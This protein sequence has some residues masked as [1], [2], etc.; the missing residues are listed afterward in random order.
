[1]SGDNIETTTTSSPPPKKEGIWLFRCTVLILFVDLLVSILI[2][3]PILPWVRHHEHEHDDNDN[4][5]N[6]NHYTF[7]G[8]LLDL[9]ILSGCR[10][11]SASIAFT[12]SFCRGN[13]SKE[14][15][16]DIYH[17]NKTKKTRDELEEEALQ[18]SFTTW[19][20]TYVNRSAVPFEIFCFLTALT[21]VLK[22]LDR[23]NIEM[24]LLKDTQ[25]IHP[26]FWLAFLFAAI[27]SVLEMMYVDT[28]CINLGKWGSQYY[29]DDENN[30][31]P[32]MLRH[33]S[34]HLSLSLLANDS[35]A[36]GGS[37][38]EENNSNNNEEGDGESGSTTA[39][40]TTEQE[41]NTTGVSDICGDTDYKASW[42]DLIKL[43]APDAFLIS[44]AAVFLVAA[45]LMQIYIPKYTGAILDALQKEYGNN[46]DDTK[47]DDD[48][49]RIQDIPGFMNNVKK[50]IIVSILSGVFSG[51]RGSIFMVVGGRV[52]VRLRLRLMSSLLTYEQGFFDLTKT[53]DIT[54]R[55]SSDTTLVGDQVTL[56]V[57]VSSTTQYT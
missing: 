41:E 6:H 51:V 8:S 56:N 39:N 11:V 9:L 21:S 22:C 48:D 1:M 10:V 2:C 52:N 57:N 5:H 15:S 4:D 7:S 13:I 26:I 18:Q 24:G 17:K 49:D 38:G 42:S 20:C 23:L 46:D 16:F 43:C 47:N 34:S 40:N 37:G 14:Y 54:S 28:T 32:S 44:I 30:Q 50:L 12:I 53:G 3:S 31:Q 19:F 55:L 45:A 36:G 33:L 29:S 25:P 27:I 35:L